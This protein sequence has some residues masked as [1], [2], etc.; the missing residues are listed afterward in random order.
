MWISKQA[1]VLITE[2]VTDLRKRVDELRAAFYEQRDRADRAVDELLALRGLP[3]ISPQ[4]EMV[5]DMSD[6]LTEDPEQVAKI[7]ERMKAGDMRVFLEAR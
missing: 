5:Q 3:P 7:E 1:M 2:Q 6:V 4:R